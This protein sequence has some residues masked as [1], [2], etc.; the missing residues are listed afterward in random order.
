MKNSR[1]GCCKTFFFIAK[2]IYLNRRASRSHSRRHKMSPSLTGPFTFLTI[3][4][5]GSSMNSAR[6]CVTLPVFPVR[7]RTRFTL[8][9]LT[10]LSIFYLFSILWKRGKVGGD[11]C[12]SVC[13]AVP[14]RA[15]SRVA[16]RHQTVSPSSTHTSSSTNAHPLLPLMLAISSRCYTA[17]AT[18]GPRRESNP[19]P[20]LPER[21]I[22][23]LDHADE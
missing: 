10:G 13:L 4:L 7:P 1:T 16:S 17:A 6:T 9:S 11:D 22:M 20:P 12:V 5:D 18:F 21:G 19:G 2:A 15:L 23:P 3:D 8:A 14:C